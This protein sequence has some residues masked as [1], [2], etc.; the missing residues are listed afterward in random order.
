VVLNGDG[1]DEN[2]AGYDWY[3]KEQFV[4]RLEKLPRW[5]RQQAAAL[6][7]RLPGSWQH[8]GVGKNIARL[9]AVLTLTPERRYAQ[10]IE[11]L[12]PEE[13]QQLYSN[14]FQTL[15]AGNDPDAVLR[16]VF[17]Q[18]EADHGLDL[19]LDA[20]VSL[21]L[22][23]DLLVKMDRATMAHSLEA[24]SPFLDHVLMEFVATLPPQL[25]LEGG[26]K[27]RLLRAA[28]RGVV[29]DIILDRP[30]MGFSTPLARWFRDDLRT[31]AHDILLSARA[32]Q[33]GY[34]R[35]QKIAAWLDEH[36]TGQQD[37]SEKLWN[38][39]LLE[40]WQRTFIDREGL[41]VPSL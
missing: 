1:G 31:M 21:F 34:F 12:S 32:T 36:S 30:K 38:L 26:Q 23:D 13:R 6:G 24:R 39:L 27:K 4:R 8:H 9:A 17:A 19:A 16:T 18:S 7:Q 25:K 37:H 33:R 41:F 14:D 29:P 15:V 35:P 40:M 10:W 22:A 3:I 28:L 20:D 2:F 11:P 5:L